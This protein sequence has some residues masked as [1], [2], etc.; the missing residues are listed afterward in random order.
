V[1]SR[2]GMRPMETRRAAQ[3]TARSKRTKRTES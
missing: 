2:Q 3:R 1:T